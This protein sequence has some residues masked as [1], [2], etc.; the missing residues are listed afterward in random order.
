MERHEWQL[1]ERYQAGECTPEEQGEAQAV[2]AKHPEGALF[3]AAVQAIDPAS[4]APSPPASAAAYERFRERVTR[5][6]SPTPSARFVRSIVPVRL[7]RTR[8]SGR[9]MAACAGVAAVVIAYVGW[10]GWRSSDATRAPRSYATAAGRSMSLTLSDRSRVTLAPGSRLVVASDFGTRTRSVQIEGQGYFDVIDAA[11][12]PFIVQTARA[13]IRV[14][15]TRFTVRRY[16][17]DSVAEVAVLSGKIV[18][19]TSVSRATL[20]AGR[21]AYLADSTI[22]VASPNDIQKYAGWTDGRLS[23]DGAPASVVLETLGRW[24]G[25]EFRLADSALAREP[26]KAEFR[27]GEPR[28]AM[29]ILAHVLN[30]S[31]AV[32]GTVATLRTKKSGRTPVRSP[33]MRSRST[34][35]T[36]VGK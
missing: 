24:Y 29:M 9:I 7:S 14:L 13:S 23:F 16:A 17:T 32:D 2:L 8:F 4:I 5:P 10:P 12:T 11:G 22:A 27:I 15:G 28:E 31:V 1:L 33:D 6:L 36:E 25:Y 18:A 19:T 30:V 34:P 20:T 35:Y 26:V 3:R 21:M